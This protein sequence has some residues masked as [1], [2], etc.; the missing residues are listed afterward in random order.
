LTDDDDRQRQTTD[1]TATV[2][3]VS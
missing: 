3:I 2:S 1:A